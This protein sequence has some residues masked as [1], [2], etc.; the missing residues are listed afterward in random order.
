MCTEGGSVSPGVAE[1]CVVNHQQHLRSKSVMT[2]SGAARYWTLFIVGILLAVWIG[3]SGPQVFGGSGTWTAK[4]PIS[5]PRDNLAVGAINGILYVVGGA[6]LSG[7]DSL[8][9]VE[10]YDPAHNAW[11]A[12]TPMAMPRAKHAVGVV[13]GILYAMGGIGSGIGPDL[14]TVEAYDPI[15]NVW[16]PKAPMPT[17]RWGF[18]VG[19]V[20]GVLYAVG[21]YG[22]SDGWLGTVEAF[23]PGVNKWTTKAPM[24]TARNYLAVGV[25]NGILYAVGGACCAPGENANI[26]RTVEAYDPTTNT[27]RAKAPMPTPRYGLAVGV[28]NGILYAVGGRNMAPGGIFTTVEAYDPITNRWS[29]KAPMPAGRAGLAVG[30]IDGIL[31]V[32]GGASLIKGTSSPTGW[33]AQL[34]RE[35]LAFKP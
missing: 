32:V 33:K 19:V 28:I 5:T 25:T 23:D 7:L 3:S 29:A 26:L 27:W 14:D 24:P 1:A 21:G 13:K 35:L 17:P 34:P 2:L 6:P 18:A 22:G 15:R 12:K 20:N 9:T 4:T 31:Y 30:T 16:T 8:H 11:T 10:A